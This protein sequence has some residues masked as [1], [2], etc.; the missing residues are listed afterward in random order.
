VFVARVL[1]GGKVTIPK[2][3][4]KLLRVVIMCDWVL[5]FLSILSLRVVEEFL[6]FGFLE[7]VSCWSF[8]VVE[9]G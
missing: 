3:L 8:F 4:R 9:G 7:Y 2:R 1:R 5:L 6:W